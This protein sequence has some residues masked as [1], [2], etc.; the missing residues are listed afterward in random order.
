MSFMIEKILEILKRENDTFKRFF[1]YHFIIKTKKELIPKISQNV[2]KFEEKVVLVEK[3]LTL[4]EKLRYYE[5][6]INIYNTKR[7]IFPDKR[8]VLIFRLEDI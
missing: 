8:I 7:R 3:D 1:D 2:P 4:E 5:N 6:D